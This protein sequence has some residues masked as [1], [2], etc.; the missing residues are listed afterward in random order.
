MTASILSACRKRILLVDD[1]SAFLE[2]LSEGLELSDEEFE[3]ST[4]PDGRKALE[5][6]RSGRRIDLLVTDLTMPEMDGFELLAN[7]RRDYPCTKAILMTAILTDE[8]RQRLEAIGN[9]SCIEKPVG[10]DELKLM[11]KGE[12]D[13][14]LAAGGGPSGQDA[15]AGAEG[16]F[17]NPG[18]GLFN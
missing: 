5:A 18:A 8:V 6:F 16:E 9:Y 7:I 1:E 2:S 4:A 10:L 14:P 11:I 17:F 15:S 13:F 12:L 3:V